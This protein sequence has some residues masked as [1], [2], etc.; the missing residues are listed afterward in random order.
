MTAEFEKMDEF[1]DKRA[2][3]YDQHMQENVDDFNT[4]YQKIAEDI[5][6]TEEP[7]SVLD[8]GCGTG[9]ELTYIFKKA[10]QA[11]ITCLDLSEKI[12]IKL[13][14]KYKNKKEQ[15]D[16]IQGSYLEEDLSDNK[17]DYIIS[18]MTVHHLK[19]KSKLMLYKKIQRALKN[20]GKYIEGDYV[21]NQKKE[22]Q[23]LAEYEK[24]ISDLKEEEG[25]YNI[26][27]PL[28]LKTQ[29]RLF[30]KSDFKDFHLLYKKGEAAIYTMM[31]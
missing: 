13:K 21:V 15:I 8:I 22:K 14:E 24:K 26:D 19:Y 29:K 5:K 23:L 11:H 20:D 25:S 16:L 6:S 17:Y 31:K 27:I 12:L 1:F 10:P 3:N 7:V 28:S 18:V 4:F 30:V 2:A 9:L